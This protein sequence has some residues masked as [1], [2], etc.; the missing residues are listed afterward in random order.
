MKEKRKQS[1]KYDIEDDLFLDLAQRYSPSLNKYIT[2][3][4]FD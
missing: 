2:M 3:K 1:S 4:A